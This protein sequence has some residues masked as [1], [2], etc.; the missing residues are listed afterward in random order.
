M[1]HHSQIKLIH[2]SV[3]QLLE[4]QPLPA[5][6]PI[7][8]ELLKN[9]DVDKQRAAAEI[10]AGIIGGVLAR[11][12]CERLTEIHPRLEALAPNQAKKTLAVAQTLLQSYFQSKF[13]KR[14]SGNLVLIP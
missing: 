9:K 6:K 4:D 12:L 3:V 11:I 13:K 8:D 5:V 7:L 2:V 10:A 1:D 14:Y